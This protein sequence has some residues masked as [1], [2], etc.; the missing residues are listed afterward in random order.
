MAVYIKPVQPTVI[1]DK[2]IIWKIKKQKII[3]MR[4][5]IMIQD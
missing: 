4:K 1:K 5:D 2:K 3:S